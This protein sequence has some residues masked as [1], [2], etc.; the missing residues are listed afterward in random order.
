MR[1]EEKVSIIIT[2]YKKEK[3]L[4]KAIT[5][6]INQD[7]SN[8]EISDK[9]IMLIAVPKSY[10]HYMCC[11]YAL[12]KATGRFATFLGG[13]DFLEKNH[14]SSLLKA[15]SGN[16]KTVQAAICMY[17][18]QDREGAYRGSKKICEAALF[19]ERARVLSDI[20]YFH[21]VRFGADSEFRERL[22]AYYGS[23]SIFNTKQLT[24]KSLY[25]P[26]SL[27]TSPASRAGSKTRAVYV[28]RFRKN[29]KEN[30]KDCF[31]DY[32]TDRLPFSA[33]PN[34]ETDK[35][36]IKFFKEIKLW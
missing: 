14:I 1:K 5:S 10:G 8:L 4:R 34:N 17:I 15:V 18:R 29:I 2:N 24:Y 31:F 13:D 35:F 21:P 11:N 7:H 27:T 28:K 36:D 30:L 33:G 22:L 3:F 23:S 26:D 6:C 20:G 32:K 12:D 16:K 19:F 9:R 25:L